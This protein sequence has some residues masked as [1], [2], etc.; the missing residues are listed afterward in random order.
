MEKILKIK[1]KKIEF[2]TEQKTIKNTY[3]SKG[4]RLDIY[5]A[6]DKGTIYNCEMQTV[7]SLELPRRSRY[8]SSTIDNDQLLKGREYEE[9]PITYVIFICTFDYFREGRHI[10]TFEKTCR[11]DK[12][13]I[14]G[15]EAYTIFLNSKGT[16]NDVDED[17][18]EFLAYIENTTDD[19]ADKSQSEWI[20]KLH[21]RVKDVKQSK[22]MEVEF[23][24]LLQRDRE[25]KKEAIDGFILTLLSNGMS[26]QDIAEKANISVDYVN[27]LAANSAQYQLT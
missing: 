14:L 25:K 23:M 16:M 7:E 26:A 19:Y 27:K 10:Y 13:I 21:E 24:T 4:V 5:I 6:D 18:K 20:K 3:E 17:V 9:L 11:E 8:Y 15:D 12:N 2:A 22:E 1:I